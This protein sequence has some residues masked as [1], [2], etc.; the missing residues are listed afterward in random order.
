[1][2]IQSGKNKHRVGKQTTR[3]GKRTSSNLPATELDTPVTADSVNVAIPSQEIVGVNPSSFIGLPKIPMLPV[4][5]TPI[6]AATECHTSGVITGSLTQMHTKSEQVAQPVSLVHNI[7]PSSSVSVVPECKSI[8]TNK[9]Q[10]MVQSMGA[11]DEGKP[12]DMI[13]LGMN[14]SKFQLSYIM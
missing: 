10:N 7:C 2:Y 6:A 3:K 11:S 9:A 4:E 1:L 8:A 12:R 14:F 13:T 5:Q